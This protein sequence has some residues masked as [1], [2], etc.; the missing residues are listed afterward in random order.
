MLTS[1]TVTLDVSELSESALAPA[2]SFASR[3]HVPIDLVVVS[4]PGIDP[5]EDECYLLGQAKRL[6]PWA[7]AQVRLESNDVGDALLGYLDAHPGACLV[8]AT[9]GRSGVGAT[10]LGG[11][12]ERLVRHSD[13]PVVLVGPSVTTSPR[14]GPVL[15]CFGDPFRRTPVGP[16]AVEW[17][18]A[19]H[20]PLQLLQVRE[21]HG[22]RADLEWLRHDEADVEALATALATEA[23]DLGTVAAT[24]VHGHDAPQGDVRL[25]RDID[26]SLLVVAL[27]A[28]HGPGGLLWGS[29]TMR[30]VRDAPCPVLVVP[31]G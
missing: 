22:D 3:A 4:S 14:S 28:E 7:G 23:P 6:G 31:A 17:A 12:A 26:A 21:H 9:R 18:K 20:Q 11:T 16:V 24:V 13:R 10:I 25:A 1:L 15:A 29:S 8:M 30:V 5:A 27:G 19:L 2:V